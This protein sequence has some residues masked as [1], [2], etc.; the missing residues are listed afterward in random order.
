[1]SRS[2]DA[3]LD[4][5]TMSEMVKYYSQI[6]S[7]YKAVVP[8]QAAYNITNPYAETNYTYPD[9]SQYTGGTT[10]WTTASAISAN[11][12][13]TA[14]GGSSGSASAAA[15]GQSGGGSATVKSAAAASS[16]K[17]AAG[18]SREVGGGMGMVLGLAGIWAIM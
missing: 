5:F 16:S 12:S 17:S 11:P 3:L 18:M 10:N 7:A 8:I 15:A 2:A 9:F 1:M 6:K 4:N 14:S 13:A